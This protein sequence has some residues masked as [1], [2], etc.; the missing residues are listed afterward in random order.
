M[1]IYSVFFS[2]LAHSASILPVPASSSIIRVCPHFISVYFLSLSSFVLIPS[3]L[4]HKN[5]TVN[6]A[7][8]QA[9]LATFYLKTQAFIL[10]KEFFFFFPTL[11]R[12]TR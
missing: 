1:A 4:R 2:L 10:V 11:L 7:F 5:G 8:S 12:V 9:S 3:N 6:Q